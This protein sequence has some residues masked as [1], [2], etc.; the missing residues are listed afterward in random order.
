MTQDI[1]VRSFISVGQKT[2][3]DATTYGRGFNYWVEVGLPYSENFDREKTLTALQALLEV[4]DHRALGVDQ[5]LGFEPTS[6]KLCVWLAQEWAKRTGVNPVK[7]QL[8]RGDGVIV[9]SHFP[10]A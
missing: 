2:Q 3:A 4:V 6:L 7:V 1:F 9:S 8:E 10:S 5:K